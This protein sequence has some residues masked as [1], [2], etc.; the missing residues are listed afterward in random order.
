VPLVKVVRK[1]VL[2]GMVLSGCAGK[3]SSSSSVGVRGVQNGS[4]FV[5][6]MF[7]RLLSKW[8]IA[9]ASKLGGY[10]LRDFLER[11]GIGGRNPLAMAL[12]PGSANGR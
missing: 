1:Q 11:P 9:V 8:P 2:V 7:L 3:E 12:P 10:F 6:L 5:L 4:F